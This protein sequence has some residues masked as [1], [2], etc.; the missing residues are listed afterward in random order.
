MDSL[1]KRQYQVLCFI[2]EY[3]HTHHF[4]PSYR[5]I[6]KHFSFSSLG[7]VYRYVKVL[8]NKGLL[9]SKKQCSR[10][11]KLLEAPPSHQLVELQI[12]LIG[13]ISEDKQ[14]QIFPKSSSF[15]ISPSFVHHPESTYVIQARG[16]VLIE[17][18]IADGDYLLIE[19]KQ[20]IH[21]GETILAI[22]D[23][24]QVIVKKYFLEDYYVKLISLNPQNTPLLV[25][26]D[27]V[28][29]QGVVIGV[30]RKMFSSQ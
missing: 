18:L 29:I 24:S 28:S 20:E 13:C 19:A 27:E 22:L 11:L 9:N 3:I 2:K 26:E 7:T 8:T 5:E 16:D 14:L 17:E 1:T 23:G 4:A 15:K 10:S 30:I 12:P 25:Q 6:M 21:D